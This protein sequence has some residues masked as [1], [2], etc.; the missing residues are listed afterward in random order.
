MLREARRSGL[1]FASFI[2]MELLMA[3]P[4]TTT[5]MPSI[6]TTW[7]MPLVLGVAFAWSFSREPRRF[8]NALLFLAFS[9]SF[10]DAALWSMGLYNLIFLMWGILLFSPFAAVVFLINNGRHVLAR[11]GIGLANALPVLLA[12]T[13]VAVIVLP[14]VLAFSGAPSWTFFLSLT[15]WAESLWAAFTLVALLC[16]SWFYQHLPRKTAYDYIIV[17]GAGLMPDGTPT[18][19]LAGRADKAVEL[20]IDQDRRPLFVASGGKGSDEVCS[21]AEAI[22]Q[23]LQATYGVPAESILLEDRSTTT[24]ENLVYSKE[25]LDAQGGETPYRCCLVTSD[26]HVFR[27]VEFS[28]K[29]GLAA[30]GLGSQTASYYFPAAFLREYVAITRAHWWPYAVIGALGS[31]LAFYLAHYN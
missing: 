6:L 9:W 8:R 17:H 7:W 13:I 5:V 1:P 31:G 22:S 11:E 29:C 21:E 18:P 30:D 23:Y 19:L 28:R 15:V 16:Y 10:L 26:Y 27:A 3:S 12:L 20:W 14:F 24:W 4:E 25:L 2:E